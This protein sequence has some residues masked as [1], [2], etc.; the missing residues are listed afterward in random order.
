MLRLVDLIRLS[1]VELQNYKIHCATDN[2]ESGW[3]PLEQYFAGT[4]EFGQTQQSQKNF[5]CKQVLSLI[6]LGNGK[7]WLFVG[8]YEVL[9]VRDAKNFSGYIYQLRRLAGLEH[10]E[11]RAIVDFPKQFRASYLVGPTHAPNLIIESIREEK[12]S[13]A[14][15]P[16]FNGVC[17][18]FEMLCSVVNQDNPSWRA[19]LKNVAGVYLIADR[20]TGYQYVGSAYGGVGIWQRWSNYVKTRHGGNKELKQLLHDQGEDHAFEFQFSLLEVCDI[21]SSSDYV[22]GRECHWKKILL[23]R[24]FGLNWN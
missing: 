13:I 21:N 7:R 9:G 18:T 22:I 10:L 14:E 12:M 20:S 3:K 24:E 6:N 2:K 11:G 1:G 19:G 17:L 16:G 4:F 8:V 23:S 5:E 15:F